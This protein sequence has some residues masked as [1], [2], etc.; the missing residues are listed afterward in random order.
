ME[1]TFWDGVVAG[2]LSVPDRPLDEMTTEL[3]RMLGSTDP[4]ARDDTAFTVLSNWIE[5]GTYDDLLAGLGDGM[6]AGL[7]AGLG[8]SGT[9]SVFRRSFSA[10]VLAVCIERANAADLLPPAK[11]L[12]WGDRIASWYLREQDLRGFVPGK[13]WAHA[14]AHGADGIAA[15]ANTPSFGTA[16]LTVLL[17]VLADRV[18][19]PVSEP[20]AAG[21]PD[22]IAAAVVTVLSR[23]VVPLGVLE[24]WVRRLGAG[25]TRDDEENPF[26]RTAFP[27]ALL[28]G[29]YLQLAAG[30]RR[31]SVRADLLL[32][33]VDVL[34]R[35]NPEYLGDP[36]GGS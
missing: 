33:L 7:S 17:D 23:E 1:S 16:E 32:V 28:R 3:T 22:R 21:E 8:E 13:G 11:L 24:P 29:L 36:S 15:L 10:L 26:P 34:R 19:L 18:L 35:T 6:A 9:D 4:H 14:L 30:P 25:A 5:Q 31:P 2:G 20:P 27:Q 12:E